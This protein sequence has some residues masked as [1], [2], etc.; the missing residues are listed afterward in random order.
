M[1]IASKAKQSAHPADFISI[2]DIIFGNPLTF[3]LPLPAQLRCLV[4]ESG[5]SAKPQMPKGSKHFSFLPFYD[6]LV[7]QN[8]GLTK[9]AFKR[10]SRRSQ[11]GFGIAQFRLR[12]FFFF[13]FWLK[14]LLMGH[15]CRQ[16]NHLLQFSLNI[17]DFF[18]WARWRQNDL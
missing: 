9:R 13:I 3:I 7:S 12:L 15:L 6:S 18:C 5:F 8:G 10:R 4:S 1:V 17:W 14:F 2:I 11:S 16:Q